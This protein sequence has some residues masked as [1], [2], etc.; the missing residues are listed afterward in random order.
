MTRCLRAGLVLLVL[1]LGIHNVVAAQNEQNGSRSLPCADNAKAREFDFWIGEWNVTANGKQAGTNSVQR[2]LG[3]CVIFENWTSAGGGE[4]KS[5][6]FY[7]RQTD[8]WQ[9]VWVDDGGLVLQLYG[10]FSDG[11]MRFKG[12][13]L[14]RDKQTVHHRLIF[15]PR[16]D[17]S[18]R[19]FWEQSRDGGESW[20]VSFDGIYTRK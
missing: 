19:Q 2:I 8:Q 3:Q 6:N 15:F 1:I 4:G 13:T 16:E 10:A 14:G 7:N 9:Q 11:A 5:F 12:E 20:T 17:S 18:V